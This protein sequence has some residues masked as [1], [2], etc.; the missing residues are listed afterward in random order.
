MSSWTY[1][2]KLYLQ[3]RRQLK[4]FNETNPDFIGEIEEFLE[5]PHE[6]MDT[7]TSTTRILQRNPQFVFFGYP[8]FYLKDPDADRDKGLTD[9]LRLK[10]L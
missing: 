5:T 2:N 6:L 10:K 7:A 9:S 4:S 1:Y 3:T 8:S